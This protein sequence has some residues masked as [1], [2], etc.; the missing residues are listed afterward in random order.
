[1]NDTHT[2]FVIGD[3]FKALL[4][5]LGTALHVCLDDDSKLFA[6]ALGNLAEQVVE[7]DLLISGKLFLL[8]F[9]SAAVGQLTRQLLVL[10]GVNKSPAAGTS[11]KPVISTGVDGPASFKI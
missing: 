7:R 3:F 2:H 8:G 6:L 11:V 5:G 10:N 4:N 9:G 1:M